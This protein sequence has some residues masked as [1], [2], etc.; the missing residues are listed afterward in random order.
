MQKWKTCHC[1]SNLSPRCWCFEWI[2]VFTDTF[3]YIFTMLHAALCDYTSSTREVFS[4]NF[5]STPSNKSFIAWLWPRFF[6][7][8]LFRTKNHGNN[9][10]KRHKALRNKNVDGARHK[11]RIN[12]YLPFDAKANRESIN[13]ECEREIL[14]SYASNRRSW[15][16]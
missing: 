14:Q 1:P 2:T 3:N 11:S 16:A 12:R 4:S 5:L 15:R 10:I 9:F 8:I 13:L 6:L 7:R